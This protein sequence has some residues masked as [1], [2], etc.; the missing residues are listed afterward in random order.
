MK[1]I[2]SILF[3]FFS[4]CIVLKAAPFGLLINETT[5][6][7][8][9]A[10]SETD[11][12]GREQFLVSCVALQQGDK[13]QLFDFGSGGSWTCAI[14]P[15]GE[16]EKFTRN[17]YHY[18][19]N[20]TGSYDFYIRMKF[21]DDLLYIGS[22]QNCS[23]T[24]VPSECE[25]VMLQAFYYDSYRDGAP[26]DVKINGK[27]LGNTKWN[28]LL[29]QS[30]EIG[31]YFDLVWLPPSGKSEGG[32]GY[33]QTVYSNQ[34]SDWGSQKELIEFINR[35]HAANTKVVADIVINHAGTKSSWCDF[36]TQYFGDYGTFE[37]DASWIAQTDEVNSAAD[38]GDC[39]GKATGPEDGG[40]NGQDNYGAARDW[41]HAKPE[42]QEMMKAYLKWMKNVIGFDGWR[43]DYAQGFKGKY[44]DMYNS[45][46]ENYFSVVEFW[47]GDMNN[48]KSYLND[49]NW[50]TLAFDIST[51]Y[52]AIQ[53][54]AD[55]KYERCKGSG[56]LGAGLSKYAVT[57][58]DSHDTY[59][60]CKGGRD[61][62]D[63]IGGCGRSMED[64]NKDRVLGANAFILSMPGVPCVFYPHWAKYKD[65]IGKMVLARKAAGVHSESQVS[66]EAGSG[67]YKSTITGKHGSIRLLLGPNSGFNTTPAGYKLAYK[68]GNFAMYYTTTQAE[69]PVL[70]ITPST[71][72]KTE[73]H[74]VEMSAVALSGTPTIYYTIDGSDPTASATKKT[75][76]D[77]FTI[78]GTVTVKAYAELNGVKTAVQEATYTYQEPQ[79]TP[80]TVKFMPPATWEKV[81]LYAW[82]GA[83][84]GAWPGMEW[85][86]KDS[87]GWLY[88]VF[89]SDVRE[90]KIIFNNG[91]YEQSNDIIL[92][93]DA[94]YEWKDGVEVLSDKCSEGIENCTITT[95]VN[96]SNYGLTYG[97]TIVPW[98][99]YITIS[100]KANYG[101]HFSHWDD[102]ITENP[103][104]VLVTGSKTYIAYFNR[105]TYHINKHSGEY[106]QIYG[107]DSAFYLDEVTLSAEPHYG[108]HFTQWSDGVTDNPRTFILTQDTTFTA[109][110]APNQYN[111]STSVNDCIRGVT[112]GDTIATYLDYIDISAIAYY[113][114]HF[115]QWNDGNTE[116][117]RQIQVTKDQTFTAYFAKNS[118]SIIT[119][120]DGTAGSVKSASS[121]LYLDEVTLTAKPNCGYHFTQWLDG[122]TDNPRTFILTQDTAFTAE[123][124]QSYSG[125]CGENLYWIYDEGDQSVSITGSGEMYD[126]TATT[127]PW[128]LFK[129]QITEVT[130]SNAA[131]SIGTSAFEGC[132]RLGKVTLGSSIKNIAANAFEEC[133]RLYHIYCYPTYPPFAKQSSF[134]NY[135]VYLHIPCDYKEGY[136]LDV[137]WGNFKYIECLGA[138]SENTDGVVITPSTNDVTII[139]P[140][141]T[142]ADTYTIVIKKGNE[143]FCTLTFN[144][145][146]QLLN[147]A[148]AP[149][150]DGNHPVQ[151]AEQVVNGYRFTVTGLTEATQYAYNITTKDSDNNTIATYS[152]EFIT[153]GGTTTAV[154]D[155]LQNTTNV[156]KLL[157]NGQFLIIR[158]GIEYNAMGQE[159]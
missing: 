137:V 98:Y 153:M 23:S 113:G 36:H 118:Y 71:I 99:T 66:D 105:N 51:K 44:I 35:M 108:Y 96:N 129:E 147:I 157:R 124:A 28:V 75:Y 41:A 46:S 15:Y 132:I 156:Q 8:A 126:Y 140:T 61:N 25:D 48:I 142:G 22:G 106:G 34:N 31:T 131:T 38:A 85:T 50:N 93:Q 62:N 89:P 43:Y 12:E 63:E 110:F 146:G 122:V 109:E 14:D 21:N 73:N 76:T 55:G 138:E 6:L 29:D 40:Y 3:L 139:W 4:S 42:V 47:N 60:G 79:T 64:Y 154:E 136:N 145:D 56:L 27:Q 57:F 16:Y 84:L 152:G 77:A 117:P 78:T 52:S 70:S 91:L 112:I 116:N 115:V 119:Y 39:Q 144:A 81:Y 86:R 151:Y 149:G 87:E 95:S 37:P 128:L 49:V 24:S 107:Y 26:G 94:C 58:V 83:Y 120:Y 80:L 97:D 159:L 101:Y 72:Y 18:V 82:D 9:I 143:V 30:G 54:I 7:E 11:F 121:A 141:E 74:T 100:A 114:Y 20:V 148:F 69:A 158:D 127:H 103:R 134:T 32:T 133:N 67:Y 90:V 130:T 111:I 5:K 150:R 135:N 59:F 10:L 88:H 102:G 1:K 125:Q 17:T 13:V 19:C 155:I 104:T 53:G 92:D 2:Y 68:G 123:F 33:H 45:A 65:A